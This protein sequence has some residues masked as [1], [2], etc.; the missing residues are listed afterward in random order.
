MWSRAWSS[1]T[2]ARI[3]AA[4][5]RAVGGRVRFQGHHVF[6]ATGEDLVVDSELRFRS[7]DEM[8]DTLTTTGFRCE[9]VF[10]DWDRGPH[11]ATSRI[12]VIFARRAG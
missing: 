2:T 9:Q 12:M 6:Q 7:R 10:G 11:V 3:P 4:R 1:C 8:E 5:I